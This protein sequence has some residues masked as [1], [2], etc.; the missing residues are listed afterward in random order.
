MKT[1]L[2]WKKRWL[3]DKSGFW[4]SAKVPIL[5]W[6][7]VI[8]GIHFQTVDYKKQKNDEYSM[9]SVGMFLSSNDC[10]VIKIT[11]RTFKTKEAAI[12]ACE[13]HLDNITIKFNKWSK[14]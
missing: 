8:D 3:D 1:K 10:D 12:K 5:N 11:K 7:Y 14:R 2:N 13:N 6:E 9:F 4:Y